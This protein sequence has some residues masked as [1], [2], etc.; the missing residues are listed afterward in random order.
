LSD[1]SLPAEGFYSPRELTYIKHSGRRLSD[2]EAAICHVQPD[3]QYT[4]SEGWPHL[5]LMGGDSQDESRTRLEHH[6]WFEYRDPSSLWQRTYVRRQAVEEK[7]VANLLESAHE[8]RYFE[9]SDGFWAREVLA[10]YYQ[11]FGFLEWGVFLALNRCIR[12]APSDT[13]TMMLMFTA[14]DRLRHQQ[15]IAVLSLELEQ[16]FGE[17]DE[18]MGREAWLRD[19]AYQPARAVIERLLATDDWSE[20]AFACGLLLDPLLYGFVMRQFFRRFAPA[21]G[22][23]IVP[24]IAMAAE[25]DRLRYQTATRALVEMALSETDNKGHEI[26]GVKNR[27]VI[28]DWVDDWGSVIMKAVDAFAPVYD[29]PAVRPQSS[30]A[31]R[32][33]VMRKC[34]EILARFRLEPSWRD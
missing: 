19:P 32:Q 4:A 14:V 17:L 21:N 13:L 24:V 3:E 9:E 26:Q 30:D 5:P 22:D 11:G 34:E 27:I 12:L 25:R 16:Q 10:R 6:D 15:A 33:A 18:G 28:Q 31:A 23:A 8:E 7:A 2:Y 20:V 1:E 29:L